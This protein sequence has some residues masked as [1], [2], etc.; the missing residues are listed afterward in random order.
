MSD[1]NEQEPTSLLSN[2]RLVRKETDNQSASWF[3]PKLC[4]DPFSRVSNTLGVRDQDNMQQ[5]ILSGKTFLLI[6]LLCHDYH[7][8]NTHLLLTFY[9]EKQSSPLLE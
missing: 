8:I 2:G 5:E 6:L 7:K 1:K 3:W 9:C 4:L